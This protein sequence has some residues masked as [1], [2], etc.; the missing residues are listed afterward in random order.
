LTACGD[1]VEGAAR[2]ERPGVRRGDGAVALDVNGRG[3]GAA[4]ENAVQLKSC[5][6]VRSAFSAVCEMAPLSRSNVAVRKPL[7]KTVPA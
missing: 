7:V 5:E 1:E 2:D 3:D 4:I 6:T